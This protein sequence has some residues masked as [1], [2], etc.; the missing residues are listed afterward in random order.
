MRLMSI[1]YAGRA[2]RSF[3][4]GIRLWPPLNILA[5]SPCRCRRVIASEMVEGRRYS[6]AGGIMLNLFDLVHAGGREVCS[7][8]GQEE[9]PYITSAIVGESSRPE[10]AILMFNYFSWMR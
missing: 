3:I 5:S 9:I 10:H 8:R 4:I 1:T 2:S 7:T 6:K